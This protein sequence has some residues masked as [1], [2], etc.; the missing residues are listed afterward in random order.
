MDGI[1]HVVAKGESL[2]RLSS[3]YKV[4]MTQLADCNDL[5]SDVISP[6]QT[7]FI[8]GARLSSAALKQVYG[9]TVI[10][11]ARGPISS[12]FGYRADPFTGVRSYHSGIDI[13]VNMG[14]AVKAVMDA[15]VAAVGWN[16]SY[17]NYVILNHG[18][19]LQTLYGHL[20]RA[21][22]KQG[23]R[24]SQGTV[25]AYSGNTGYSTGPHLHFGV[26]RNGVLSNP[27]KLLK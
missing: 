12:Y 9:T 4:S 3:V 22:V 25:I 20:S 17:G 24:V 27:L 14:T 2:G 19:G 23:Q 1:V 8:P 16:S 21:A 26:Y 15:T 10:W 5:G 7:L 13:V 11:P 18:G 6:G